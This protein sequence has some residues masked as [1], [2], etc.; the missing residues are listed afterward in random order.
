M[1]IK[2]IQ[3]PILEQK[4]IAE[5]T[6]EV[7][8]DLSEKEFI[9]LAGQY[10]RLTLPKLLYADP[11]GA[12]RIFSIASSPNNKNKLTVVFRQSG[13]GF[14]KTLMELAP[15]SLVEIEGPFGYLTFPKDL[16]HPLVFI[17]GGVG[18]APFLSMIRFTTEQKLNCPITLLYG[19]KDIESAAYLEE[20]E[21]IAKQNPNFLLKNKFGYIDENFIRESVNDLNNPLWYI[22]GPPKMVDEMRQLLARLGIEEKK[23]YFE[24]FG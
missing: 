10:I 15:G 3:L 16:S 17:A 8:F 14:K 7:S 2:K 11:Q 13:S 9:F 6:C 22:A 20:L 23:I 5:Q 1:E 4:I 19:N 21:T 12:S 24:N 18:I